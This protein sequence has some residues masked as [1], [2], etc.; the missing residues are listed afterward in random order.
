MVLGFYY[1]TLSHSRSLTTCYP[2][3]VFSN[4]EEAFQWIFTEQVLPQL[5]IWV[6]FNSVR[7][8]PKKVDSLYSIK[9]SKLGAKQYIYKNTMQLLDNRNEISQNYIRITVGRLLFSLYL[10]HAAINSRN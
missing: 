10:Y 5:H 7:S 3:L 2:K 6:R 8:I 9:C 1:L 4:L